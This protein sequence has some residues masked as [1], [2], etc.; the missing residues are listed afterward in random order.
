MRITKANIRETIEN[1][2]KSIKVRYT[3]E[4]DYLY[5]LFLGSV[6]GFIQLD[7]NDNDEDNG[8]A[9]QL[10]SPIDYNGN[11]LYESLWEN[12]EYIKNENENDYIHIPKENA[13]EE[14][15]SEIEELINNVKNINNAINKISKKIDQIKEICEEYQLELDTFIE[16]LYDFED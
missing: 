8:L 15:E 2:L 16:I 5:E 13:V 12:E 14:L 11:S 1:Y 7:L 10:F 3:I 4:E 6:N 9:I